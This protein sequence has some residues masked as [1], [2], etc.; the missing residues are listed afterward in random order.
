MGRPKAL[1]PLA[2]GESF[3]NHVVATL[4]EAGI[5][6]VVVVSRSECCDGIRQQLSRDEVDIVINPTPQRGQ[7][8]SLQCGL[9]VVPAACR[10]VLIA[11]VDVPLATAETV[12][13][14]IE[15]LGRSDAD[16]VRPER[17]G[18]HGHPIVVTRAVAHALSSADDSETARS[19][20]RRFA[21]KTVDVR[22][23]DEG[24][25]MDVDTPEDYGRISGVAANGPARHR[26]R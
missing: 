2:D 3:L 15:A 6:R 22:V 10:A 7:L 4:M 8:S 12:R 11:L 13:A 25:F 24:P 1:L 26:R 14:L 17:A 19:V 9:S 16:V 18:R 23:D 5:V 21:P 20:L